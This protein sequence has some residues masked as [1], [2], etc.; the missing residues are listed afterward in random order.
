M[1]LLNFAVVHQF[2]LVEKKR[3]N[4]MKAELS[5]NKNGE[6]KR[7]NFINDE[8]NTSFVMYAVQIN[9]MSNTNQNFYFWT[10]KIEMNSLR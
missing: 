7:R 8:R 3:S 4:E 2:G 9:K 10:R 6:I 1:A 5:E